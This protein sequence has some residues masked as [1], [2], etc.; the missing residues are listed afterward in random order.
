MIDFA[1]WMAFL[2]AVVASVVVWISNLKVASS[3][4]EA[5]S[6]E[7]LLRWVWGVVIGLALLK[8]MMMR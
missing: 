2:V 1:F 8:L 3:S 5:Q 7:V 6:G 4:T